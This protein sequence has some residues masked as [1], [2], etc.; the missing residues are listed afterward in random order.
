[1]AWPVAWLWCR[2]PASSSGPLAVP[3]AVTPWWHGK[4]TAKPPCTTVSSQA[5]EQGRGCLD[6]EY[7]PPHSPP[8]CWCELE[9]MILWTMGP[10]SMCACM[11]DGWEGPWQG[12]RFVG[13]A[14]PPVPPSLGPVC[15]VRPV[16]PLA[17]LCECWKFYPA[18]TGSPQREPSRV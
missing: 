7:L 1:M 14:G 10:A 15:P 17:P 3:P 8:S 16:S 9:T 6:G 4:A 13:Q 5:A 2:F 18:G 12:S 11:H